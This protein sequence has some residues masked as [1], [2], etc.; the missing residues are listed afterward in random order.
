MAICHLHASSH[1]LVFHSLK[2]KGRLL[3]EASSHMLSLS[4]PK[5]TLLHFAKFTS[6]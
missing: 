1:S 4:M 2:M 6:T 3:K 5:H